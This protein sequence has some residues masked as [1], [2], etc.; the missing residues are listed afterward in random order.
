M[1]SIRG[2]FEYADGLTPGQSKEGGIHHNL[3]DEEM[4]LVGHATFVPDGP[5]HQE[6]SFVEPPS[7][8]AHECHCGAQPEEPERLDLEEVLA[9]LVLLV[10]FVQWS[11]PRLKR[12]WD[13]R[14]RPFVESTRGKFART[15][16]TDNKDETAEPLVSTGSESP[17]ASWE[18]DAARGED[19]RSMCSEEAPAR[20][21]AALMRRLFSEEQLRV[22][23]GDRI[24]A[25]D[26]SSESGV[27]V[28]PT[29]QQIRDN[30]RLMLEENPSLLNKESQS[31]LVRILRRVRSVPGLR[32]I[33]RRSDR[34]R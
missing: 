21:A 13:G 22:L 2:N 33:E 11:A 17:E 28:R 20:R 4:R 26:G 7:P 8:C 14:A 6:Y 12:W 1:V 34:G 5:E 16:N 29:P 9:L 18:G 15:P 32:S 25:S 10:T 19:R 30:V 24:G 3:Y 31:E 27:L 23:R